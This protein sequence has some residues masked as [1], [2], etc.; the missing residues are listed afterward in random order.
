MVKNKGGGNRHK[1]MARK[2]VRNT[3]ITTKIRYANEGEMYAKVTRIFGQGN[4]EVRCNDNVVRLCVIRKKFRGRNKRDN[5]VKMDSIILVGLREWEVI[6]EGK[7][8]KCDLLYT[9]NDG[10]MEQLKQAKGINQAILPEMMQESMD[11]WEFSN[12]VDD[13][14]NTIIQTN[15]MTETA[16]MKN[17]IDI[18][19]DDI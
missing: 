10:Q 4:V 14:T 1:K 18:N 8:P 6:A 11:G 3:G 7:R 9:Y 12:D 5:H 19:F 2:N 17:N 15:T 16:E 13:D